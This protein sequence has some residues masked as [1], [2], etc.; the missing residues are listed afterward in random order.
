[1]V[2]LTMSNLTKAESAR[3]NGAKS[4]GPKTPQGRAISSMNAFR[5]GLSAKTLILQTEDPVKF[6]E[7]L[8]DYFDYLE[9]TNPIEVDLIADKVAARWRLRRIW[10]FETAMLDLEK[11]AQSPD[12]ERRFGKYDEDMRGGAAFSALADK[13]KGL[14]TALRYD[15]HLSRTFRRSLQEL[16]RLRG[17]RLQNKPTEPPKSQLNGKEQALTGDQK[18]ENPTHEHICIPDPKA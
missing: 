4:R 16:Y 12:F 1:M 2:F 9:P 6:A 14:S 8:N 15:I 7:M 10:R 18:Q 17:T 13:S 3:I 11:D 5:H